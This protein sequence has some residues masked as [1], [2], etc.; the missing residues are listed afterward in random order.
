MWLTVYVSGLRV[1][2]LGVVMAEGMLH[3]PLSD[4]LNV[5]VSPASPASLLLLF[6]LFMHFLLLFY[7]SL[8]FLF[9]FSCFSLIPCFRASH[10]FHVFHVS[11]FFLLFSSLFSFCFSLLQCSLASPW[12]STSLLSLL[13]CFLCVPPY[14]CLLPQRSMFAGRSQGTGFK[15]LF[16][17]AFTPPSIGDYCSLRSPTCSVSKY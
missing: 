12:S 15:N 14:L 8:L 6:L 1:F 11:L 17:V 4:R 10:C 16:S 13:P 7:S 9:I 3:A 5:K 2:C